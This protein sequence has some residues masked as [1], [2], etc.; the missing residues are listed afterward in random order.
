MDHLDFTVG[1]YAC[2]ALW[3]GDYS[4][5]T[6]EDIANVEAFIYALPDG[7][8]LE[9]VDGTETEFSRDEISGL[10]ADCF[11]LRVHL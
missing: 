6:D 5:L 8:T 1:Q 10:M 3:Y 2:T 9:A 4:A 7:H 11:T